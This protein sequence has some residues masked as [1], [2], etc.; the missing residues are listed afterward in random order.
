LFG[1]QLFIRASV[2]E[3][4]FIVSFQLMRFLTI[5]KLSLLMAMIAAGSACQSEGSRPAKSADTTFQVALLTPGPVSDAG[6]NAAAYDGLQLIRQQLGAQTALVQTTSPADFDD[7]FRDFAARGFKLIFAHGFE[8]TDAAL[9]AG[10]QFPHSY[11]VVTSGSASSANVASVTFKIEQA[12]YVLGVLAGGMSTT[13]VAGV[14]G[15]IEL[16]AIRLTFEGF[17]RGFMS[18]RPRGRVLTS[19]IGSFDDVGAAKEAALAEISQGADMLFHDADAAGLG[20]FQ[21]AGQQHVY[22]F[23]SNRDQNDV[24]PAV[25]LASAVTSIPQAFLKI[26]REVKA[27]DFHPRMIE[28][29]MAD[30]MVRI[31]MNKR[32][33]SRIPSTVMTQVIDTERAI[34]SGKIIV[35]SQYAGK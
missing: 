10:R 11:F 12:A 6:W 14:I 4:N 30:G 9:S 17:E 29:G 25:V 7:A 2:N 27:G 22:A 13:G 5:T 32:L 1:Q 21:A 34:V 23:G 20:V 15:G 19:F 24:A 31:V 33:E 3:Q 16:P 28:F 8:Y 35:P 26:A 18:V